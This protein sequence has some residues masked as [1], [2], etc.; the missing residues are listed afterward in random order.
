MYTDGAGCALTLCR[1]NP[2]CLILHA[3]VSTL[4]CVVTCIQNYSKENLD[5]LQLLL[6]VLYTYRRGW[7]K[8]RVNLSVFIPEH[9]F[10]ESVTTL[11]FGMS[12]I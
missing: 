5:L 7:P 1:E 9:T 2:F 4:L 3:F 6:T 8:I 12:Y 10:I 11:H